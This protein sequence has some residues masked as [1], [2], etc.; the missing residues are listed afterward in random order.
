MTRNVLSDYKP[1]KGMH[2]SN[3]SQTPYNHWAQIRLLQRPSSNST[4]MGILNSIHTLYI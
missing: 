2:M 1:P 3:A 4:A